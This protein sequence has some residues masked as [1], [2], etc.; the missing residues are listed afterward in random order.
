MDTVLMEGAFHSKSG[1]IA[2][3]GQRSFGQMFPQA[4]T[5]LLAGAVGC[6]VSF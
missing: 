4:H 3:V 2:E 6:W 5:N 1:R